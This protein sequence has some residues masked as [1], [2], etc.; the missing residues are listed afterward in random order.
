MTH[1]KVYGFCESKCRV[2]VSSKEEVESIE[3]KLDAEIDVRGKAISQVQDDINEKITNRQVIPITNAQTLY[4][5]IRDMNVGDE[6]IFNRITI[7][8]GE[9]GV[10]YGDLV[11]GSGV[12][13]KTFKGESNDRCPG[14]CPA[15][16]GNTDKT[17][18][19]G[20]DLTTLG[21]GHFYFD[22]KTVSDGEW[23]GGYKTFDVSRISRIEECYVIRY[24]AGYDSVNGVSNLN[25]ET[26]TF[27]LE[28]GS[29]ITKEV[30]VR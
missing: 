11:L 25:Y 13:K 14:S 9:S 23:T 21:D 6:L 2:E 10:D 3:A 20:T 28:D 26:W 7:V 5:Q 24:G 17:L 15:S 1:E 16:F 22:Y 19:S 30:C 27:T 4:D 18:V 12:F 29:I 8:P